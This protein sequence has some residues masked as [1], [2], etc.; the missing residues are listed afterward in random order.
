MGAFSHFTIRKLHII[1]R[2]RHLRELLTIHSYIY[3]HLGTSVVTDD[4][5][6]EWAEELKVLQAQ[7][8]GSIGTYDTEFQ[9]WDGSTGMHLSKDPWVVEKAQLLI[10]L[11]EKYHPPKPAHSTTNSPSKETTIDEH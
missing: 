6:Q 7:L 10:R 11:H 9:D 5:W 1:Y 3:Y 2:I 4:K 8:T